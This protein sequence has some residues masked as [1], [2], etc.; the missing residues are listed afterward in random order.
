MLKSISHFA[1]LQNEK[2]RFHFL[3][4]LGLVHGVGE[5]PGFLRAGARKLQRKDFSPVWGR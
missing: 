1:A 5:A 2:N 3:P 4:F